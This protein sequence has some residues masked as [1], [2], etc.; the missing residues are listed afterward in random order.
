MITQDLIPILEEMLYE[1][2]TNRLE[3]CLVPSR[4]ESYRD[5]GGM[6]R[7]S[8]SN[9]PKWYKDLCD[10]FPDSRPKGRNK[11][12]PRT[13]VKR[14]HILKLLDCLI[15]NH[16]SPSKYAHHIIDEAK[17]RNEFYDEH[18]LYTDEPPF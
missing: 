11:K 13:I 6:I 7:V 10:L 14:K 18:E 3:T 1:L 5:S 4:I 9:N 2:S 8:T 16:K 15:R 12:K 17:R